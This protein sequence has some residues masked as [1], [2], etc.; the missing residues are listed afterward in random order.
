MFVV[1][2]LQTNKIKKKNIYII[3]KKDTTNKLVLL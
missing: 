1:N 3:T 2:L